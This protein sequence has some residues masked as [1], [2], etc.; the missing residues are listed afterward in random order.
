MFSTGQL[1]NIS[2]TLSQSD[3]IVITTHRNPD[4][5]AMG[6]SLGLKHLLSKKISAEIV[7]LVP[8]RF[9][10]FL[11]WMP[12]AGQTKVFD[13]DRENAKAL[14][15]RANVIFCLDYNH[16]SRT[17]SMEEE[18]RKASGLKIMIDH[19]QEPDDFAAYRWSDTKASSTCELI[20]SFMDA[21]GWQ[22]SLDKDI[23]TCLYTGIMT[24]TGSFRFSATS[25][26]THRTIA[27]LMETGIQQWKIHEAI[28]NQN[29]YQKLKL[30]GY[31]FL[32]KLEVLPEYN[33]AFIAL[34]AEELSHYQHEEGDLEGLVNYALSIKGMTMGALFS[35]RDD[36]IR[37]SF[38]SVGK[39]SVNSFARKH[40]NGGG[41][42]NAAGGTSTISLEETI[43]KF[44]NSLVE[45]REALNAND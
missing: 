15:S 16:P 41:H 9:P 19:H 27:R 43:Q 13:Q 42:E 34:N 7:V 35:E 21:L 30:W 39:F 24:D 8:D 12:D 18:L 26:L 40:F 2:N 10:A 22:A 28:F 17:S 44:R 31:A 1:S 11:N 36:K 14:L 23:A 33:T 20:V 25:P 3:L 32:H 5:D 45:Y 29:T 37:I 4:A 38:R 6:S